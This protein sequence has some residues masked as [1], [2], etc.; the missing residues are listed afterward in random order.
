MNSYVGKHLNNSDNSDN[1]DKSISS[2]LPKEDMDSGYMG[3]TSQKARKAYDSDRYLSYRKRKK[4]KEESFDLYLMIQNIVESALFAFV[5]LIFVFNISVVDGNSMNPT[6]ENGDKLVIYHFNYTPQYGDIVALW[7][8]NLDNEKT[9]ERGEL[10]IKRVVGLPGDVI[11]IDFNTGEVYRNGTKLTENY[12]I[13]FDVY[14]NKGNAKYPLTVDD[15]CVFVLGDNRIHSTDSRFVKRE[16]QPDGQYV[17]CIDM[18]YIMG[19]AVFRVSP[20]D[21]AGVLQ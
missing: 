1:S 2:K 10:I 16:D 13:D 6:L 3:K 4:K 17:G 14:K 8:S 15:N 12:V 5:L 7:A 19:R 9:G 18:R 21:K 20:F 11:E